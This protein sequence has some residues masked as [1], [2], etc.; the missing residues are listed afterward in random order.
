[1][2][3]AHLLKRRLAPVGFVLA[4]AAP[5]AAQ[6][7]TTIDFPDAGA[8][9]PLDIN[10]S[11][12][13]VGRYTRALDATEHGFVRSQQGALTS[14]DYPGSNFTVAAGINARGDIVG[15]FRLPTD[16]MRARRG[17]VLSAGQF[18]EINPPG[19]LFTNVLGIGPSGDIVGRYCTILPCTSESVY[20]HGFLYAEGTYT[21]IDVPGAL[22][23]NAWKITPQAE[24]L[25]GYTDGGGEKHL[26]LLTQ[27]GFATLEV[28]GVSIGVDNGAVNTHGEIV[29]F[30]CDSEPC[31]GRSTDTHGFLLSKG[32]FTS[33]DVPGSTL[34]VILS[35]NAR[36]DIVGFYGDTSGRIHG[37]LLS[38]WK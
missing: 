21:T 4:I 29:G 10:A 37:F 23:T 7:F 27:D 35:I 33:V 20:V 6:S 28:P 3:L 24:I 19:S 15:Q 25:G 22:G 9:V 32:E 38:G 31:I 34:T 1:M 12:D 14:I 11:G 30:Y 13:I 36:G 2:Q 18:T 16:A 17:F 26:F 5:T 8:T